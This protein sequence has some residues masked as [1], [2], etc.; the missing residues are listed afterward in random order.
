MSTTFIV[1]EDDKLNNLLEGM[2]SLMEETKSLA[3]ENYLLKTRYLTAKEV[4]AITG[5][6]EKTIKNRKE[7]IGYITH[8][9]DLKFLIE[10]VN[11]WM[12]NYYVRPKKCG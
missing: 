8:G 4:G 1:F 3:D 7:E 9:K 12:M 11:K 10:D 5:Y 6:D 2:K